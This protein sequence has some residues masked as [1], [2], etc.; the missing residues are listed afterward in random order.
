MGALAS[1]PS[2]VCNSCVEDGFKL[3]P[4]V[5]AKAITP[6][7]KWLLLNSPNNPTGAVYSRAELRGL[8]AEEARL[9][10]EVAGLPALFPDQQTERIGYSSKPAP[11]RRGLLP[12]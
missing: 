6:H 8:E 10:Q 11:A 1:R 7:T 3:R 12:H 2:C 9:K 4:E 5:L